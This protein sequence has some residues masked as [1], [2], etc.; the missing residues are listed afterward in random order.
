MATPSSESIRRPALPDGVVVQVLGPHADA[1]GVIVEI[2]RASWH[3]DDPSPQWTLFVNEPGVVRGGHVH[4]LH[5]DRLALVD[6]ELE[7]GLVD[8]RRASPTAGLVTMFTL[9]QY[10]VVTVPAGVVHVFCSPGR[11]VILN[12]TSHE[13]DPS[14][15]LEVRFDDPAFA[16]EWSVDEPL[17]SPRDANAPDFAEF[18][19]RCRTRGIDA[20]DRPG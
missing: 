11:T 19:E 15:D 6:G 4:R 5:R 10:E 14:D 12:S 20:I 8:V 17:L 1:R 3:A 7:I 2:D 13:Y 16:F 9:R 18:L